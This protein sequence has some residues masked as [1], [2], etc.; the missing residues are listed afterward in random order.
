M[1]TVNLYFHD[2]IRKFPLNIHKYFYLELSE[3]FPMD[4]KTSSN[5]PRYTRP[6]CSIH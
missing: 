1:S 6:R 3:E 2:K 5:Q 4:S